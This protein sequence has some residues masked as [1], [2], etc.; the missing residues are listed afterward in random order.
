METRGMLKVFG[1]PFNINNS[2]CSNTKPKLFDWTEEDCDIE[3]FIDHS[4]M[5]ELSKC[6]N[7]S[8]LRVG[9]LCES[10]MINNNLYEH[11]KSNYKHIFSFLDCIFTSDEYLLSLDLRFK[12]CYSCSNMLS[13]MCDD[14][15]YEECKKLYKGKNGLMFRLDEFQIKF[16]F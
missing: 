16:E 1:A 3:V 6:K 5:E 14:Y 2:S 10:T 7:K 13:T 9:W 15:L 8:T 11:I 4:M 12:F